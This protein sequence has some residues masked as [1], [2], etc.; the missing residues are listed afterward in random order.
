MFLVLSGVSQ[1]GSRVGGHL[2]EREEGKVMIV[3]RIKNYD[4]AENFWNL[5]IYF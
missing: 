4:I 2:H 3:T 1:L 5:L